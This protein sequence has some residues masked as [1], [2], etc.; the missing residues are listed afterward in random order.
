MNGGNQLIHIEMSGGV[1]YTITPVESALAR[2]WVDA[3][4]DLLAADYHLEK[5]FC[6]MGFPGTD[7]DLNQ[8]C[9]ELNKHI[10]RINKS[11]INYRIEEWFAPESVWFDVANY[12]FNPE[13][14]HIKQ[15]IL[16]KLHN[17]FE[18]LQG[19]V[20]AMSDYYIRAEP[21]VKYSIRQLNLICHE[22][23]SW[24]LGQIKHGRDPYWTRPSQIT[25]F[26][27]APRMNLTAEHREA[28]ATNGYDR[29]F[30]GV[31]MHWCQIGKTYYEVFK[32]EGA[33]VLTDT[34]CEAINNLQYYSGEFDIEWGRDVVAA[35]EQHWHNKEMSEYSAWLV[36]NGL[37]PTDT[38]LSLG[39]L[40][41]GQVD[42]MSSF[43]TSDPGE[44]WDIM[45]N[46]LNITRITIGDVTCRYDYN[47]NDDNYEE[48]QMQKLGF[49][50]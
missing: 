47:I 19:T 16:N 15:D 30:G 32:D 50:K 29:V 25:T 26:L 9:T 4:R 6:F 49:I 40:P 48:L 1:E 18:R 27:N 34:V 22:M 10:S 28:F 2:D 20:T 13:T 8:L 21:S 11:P 42:I 12:N 39:Y 38:S 46:A 37:D 31:Y 17:H 24:V 36:S 43:G 3:L 44:V 33:P 14:L 45:S 41:L 35:G 5:N 7:R 23:E